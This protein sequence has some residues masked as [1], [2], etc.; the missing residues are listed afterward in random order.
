MLKKI[1][2]IMAV[3]LTSIALFA[4]TPEVKNVQLPVLNGLNQTEISTKL[5]D[6]GF[7]FEFFEE[8]N[9]NVA[10]GTFVRYGDN[11]APGLM[12]NPSEVPLIIYLSTHEM[13][14]PDLTGMTESEVTNALKG[15]QINVTFSYRETHDIEPGLFI[16]YAGTYD[17]GSVVYKNTNVPIVI[18]TYPDSY[19]SP[20]FISK[21]VSGS[22]SDKALEIY[23][24]LDNEVDL[25]GYTLD[26][27]L[28]GS[29]E[30]TH[31]YEF[32]SNTTLAGGDTLLL[33]HPNAN[34]ALKAK[35][36]IL[37][38]TLTFDGNDYI[39]LNDYIGA[40]IDGF[41]NQGM[42]IFFFN[43]QIRVRKSNIIESNTEF[44][45]DEWDIYHRNHYEI[46]D[47]HPTEFPTTFTYHAEHLELD[48]FDDKNGMLEVTFISA[49]DGDTAR[50]VGLEESVRFMGINS[51]EVS[52]PDPVRNA[53]A[54][55]AGAFVR[56]RL[57]NAT[58]IYLHHDP[59]GGNTETYGRYLAFVWYDGILLNY[60][61][62][63]YGHSQN[64]YNDPNETLIYEG[65]TLNEWFRR[66][67]SYARAN[68]LGIWTLS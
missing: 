14:L 25:S 24:G 11:K 47:N 57:Q 9:F 26:F 54:Q 68:R 23:N 55:A 52:D 51:L 46:L 13:V 33:V 31:T 36:D 38:D 48:F 60:E 67:E 58:Q 20:I 50:F 63:L 19:Q 53:L 64:F 44:T 30:V 5:E 27:Y 32:E 56:Q 61:V 45:T 34:E 6:L 15:F 10:E 8:L 65:V 40:Q 39:A 17:A 3:L 29:Q 43:N 7:E 28:N 35:A 66:A 18:S 2:S 4:C 59:Y 21:Y 12:L 16:E 62:V 49:N 37:T 1:Y 22:G 42:E 41:G